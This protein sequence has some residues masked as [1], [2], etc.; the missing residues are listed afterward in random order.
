MQKKGDLSDFELSRSTSKLLITQPS[1]G[2]TVCKRENSLGKNASL[3]PE[4]R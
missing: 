3:M 2:F 1:P 4:V